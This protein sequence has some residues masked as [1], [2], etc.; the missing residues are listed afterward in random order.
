MFVGTFECMVKLKWSALMVYKEHQCLSITR[1]QR[2]AKRCFM[3]S[4]KSAAASSHVGMCISLQLSPDIR[5]TGLCIVTYV[6]QDLVYHM[7]RIAYSLIMTRS[8]IETD[9]TLSYLHDSSTTVTHNT[10]FK[11]SFQKV[12]H[13]VAWRMPGPT[14][15]IVIR[16]TALYSYCT[17]LI[18]FFH[19]EIELMLLSFPVH[20]HT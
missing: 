8:T 4:M 18:L 13:R 12:K 5:T 16:R 19:R 1:G 10:T 15:N 20:P 14:S 11:R 2:S 3:L 6:I 7:R 9:T 17:G